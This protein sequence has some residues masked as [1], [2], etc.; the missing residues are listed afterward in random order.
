MGNFIIVIFHHLAKA[1]TC[2][3]EVSASADKTGIDRGKQTARLVAKLN[4]GNF[5]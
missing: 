2:F 4:I 3:K 1:Q 5:Y